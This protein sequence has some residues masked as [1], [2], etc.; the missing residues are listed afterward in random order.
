M[1]RITALGLLSGGLDSTLA[2]GLLK[3]LGLDVVGVHFATGFCLEADHRRVPRRKPKQKPVR[4]EA[5]RAGADLQ[6]PVEIVP[7]GEEYLEVVRFPKYGR[8]KGFNPCIDCRIFMLKKAKTI[9]EERGYHFLFTGE[10]LGQRPMTQHRRELRLIAEEAG[11]SDRLLR[12]LSAKLLPPTLPEKKGWVRREDLL[13]FSGRSRKR[14]MALAESWGIHDYPTPA[15]G[16]CYLPDPNLKPRFEALFKLKAPENV[17]ME[18]LMLVKHGRHFFFDQQGWLIVGR[19][20]EENRFLESFK[21]PYLSLK[22]LKIPG[23][24][25]LLYPQKPDP[26]ILNLAC[27]IM[28]RYSD[29]QPG[30]TITIKTGEKTRQVVTPSPSERLESFLIQPFSGLR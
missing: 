3:K 10:V 18:D 29:A 4:N 20:Q 1:E 24:S 5:L 23:P 16:C 30:E 2:A 17:T 26:E 6:I 8:G 12:P 22:V 15:G 27:Q 25:G 14:Q 13:D 21:E 9:M 11:V 19:Y 28:A 7:I